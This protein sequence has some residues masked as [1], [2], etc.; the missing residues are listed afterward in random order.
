MDLERWYH[1]NEISNRLDK[2]FCFVY[3][4]HMTSQNYYFKPKP[5]KV[6]DFIPSESTKRKMEIARQLRREGQSLAQIAKVLNVS[7]GY[8]VRLTEYKAE[9]VSDL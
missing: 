1:S 7:R 9:G 8:V 6:L 3:T 2:S 4:T 5:R